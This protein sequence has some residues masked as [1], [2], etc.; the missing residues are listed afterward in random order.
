M[1]D[2]A[3]DPAAHGW[4]PSREQRFPAPLVTL[5]RRQASG[6]PSIGILCTAAHGNGNGAM[7]G[8]LLATLADIGLGRAVGMHRNA[9]LKEGEPR[10]VSA[11]IQLDISYCGRVEIGE[12]VCSTARIERTTRSLTFASGELRCGE[13][14][15]AMMQGIFKIIRRAA[16]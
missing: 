2:V 11:T 1:T 6:L 5:W 9:H 7:H 13:Q 8:G 15:V 3:F 4:S 12:F 16:G 10:I 14:T